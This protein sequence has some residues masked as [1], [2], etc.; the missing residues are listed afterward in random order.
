MADIIETP[1]ISCHID[2]L[3]FYERQ[4]IAKTK[5]LSKQCHSIVSDEPNRMSFLRKSPN[6]Y[7]CTKEKA[8]VNKPKYP[9]FRNA[10]AHRK[11]IVDGAFS[12]ITKTLLRIRE[13][14]LLRIRTK[15]SLTVEAALAVPIF[16]LFFVLFLGLF[17]VIQTEAQMNQAISYTASKLAMESMKGEGLLVESNESENSKVNGASALNY[18]KEKVLGKRILVKQLEDMGCKKLHIKNGWDGI[19]LQSINGDAEYVRLTVEYQIILPINIFGKESV[20][21]RQSAVARRWIGTLNEGESANQWVYVTAWGTA[22]HSTPGCGYLDLSL[23]A[24]TQSQVFKLRNQSGARYYKCVFCAGDISNSKD[25]TVYITD[26]GR[27]YHCSLDCIAIKRTV[28]RIKLE[29]V[30]GRNPCSKCY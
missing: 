3:V 4:T 12:A 23:W 2:P 16:V 26:Y 8:Y 27:Q 28:M 25:E 11:Y 18:A 7:A 24:V 15:A 29:N 14:A 13:K 1:N 19:V 20:S 10:T 30:Q 17:Q 5:N 22:Y 21:V 6:E 9:S